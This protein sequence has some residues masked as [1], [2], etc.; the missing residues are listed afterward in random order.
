MTWEGVFFVLANISA[1]VGLIT[2]GWAAYAGWRFRRDRKRLA[3]RLDVLAHEIKGKHVAIAIGLGPGVGNIQGSVGTYLEQHG[4]KMPLFWHAD[5][6]DVTEE[7]ATDIVEGLLELR[8]E[9]NALSPTQVHF[10]Y[11]GPVFLGPA[12]GMAL[13]NWVPTLVYYFKEGTYHQ[14]VRL[15]RDLMTGRSISKKHP[16]KW[17]IKEMNDGTAGAELQPST[18]A[19]AADGD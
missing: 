7:R 5:K 16:I 9:L 19:G 2:A 14:M 12:L 17:D 6:R 8:R 10:F 15:D 13:G 4:M 1:V 11:G 18:D 3:Q